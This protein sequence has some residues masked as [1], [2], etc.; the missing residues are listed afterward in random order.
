M[1]PSPPPPPQTT[2]KIS[3]STLKT[4]ATISKT[5]ITTITVN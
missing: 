5:P 1:P 2:T 4:A 3:T